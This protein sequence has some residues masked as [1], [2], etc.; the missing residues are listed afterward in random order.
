M[1]DDSDAEDMPAGLLSSSPSNL[2]NDADPLTV[3]H[4]NA[5]L[6]AC[7]VASRLNLSPYASKELEDF[8]GERQINREMLLMAKLLAIQAK[9]TL[10][11]APPGIYELRKPLLDNI[12]SYVLAVLLSPKLS[13]YKG[14]IPGESVMSVLK[15]LNVN[16][17][18]NLNTDRHVYN[19][20]KTAVS[21]ELTQCR[22][23]IKK[24]I[25]ASRKSDQAI[26]SLANSLTD[27]TQCSVTVALCACLALL[28]KIHAE[29]TNEGN[30]FWDHVNKRLELMRT[31]SK[32]DS[33]TLQC[34]FARIL[35][36]DR[37]A[38]GDAANTPTP[39]YI[40]NTVQTT[41]DNLLKE[42]EPSTPSP[43]SFTA[44]TDQGTAGEQAEGDN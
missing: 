26:W 40:P 44:T 1:R 17:L 30:K 24:A 20:I 7:R 16:V 10:V 15:R 9:V 8:V 41:V 22:S 36:K 25:A 19:A 32:G 38:Y 28:R 34:A 5:T 3:S 21:S 14:A 12:T 6:Q 31:M 37:K 43:E 18:A 39:V 35:D 23:K 29:P 42:H 4:T 13:T 27:N 11:I 2:S 33:D